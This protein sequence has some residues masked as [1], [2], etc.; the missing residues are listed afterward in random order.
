M[1]RLSAALPPRQ[2]LLGLQL[3]R[4]SLEPGFLEPTGIFEHWLLRG[5]AY[6]NFSAG[7]SS[8][9][10]N[11]C[12]TA[13]PFT[14]FAGSCAPHAGLRSHPASEFSDSIPVGLFAESQRRT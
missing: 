10:F 5:S 13:K 8:I 7:C 3:V 2:E 6:D 1:V 12:S 9:L 4:E 11:S 14:E